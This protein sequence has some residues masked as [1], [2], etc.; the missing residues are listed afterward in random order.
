MELL[1]QFEI[2]L[3]PDQA[4]DVL[5][6]IPRIAPCM[7][8]A[9]LTQAVDANAYKGNV[10]VKIG[11][12]GLT[13]SGMVRFQEV[14]S[15]NKKAVVKATGNDTRGRGSA[16]AVILFSLSALPHGSS[17]SIKTD[18]N[19]VGAVAQYGRGVG[20]IQAIAAELTAAFAKNLKA[21][22]DQPTERTDSIVSAQPSSISGLSLLG[23]SMLRMVRPDGTDKTPE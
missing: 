10:S 22:L 21:E 20:I 13:F 18:L 17:V 14:D 19:L 23:K 3:L 9:V 1:N 16:N 5:L 4:W 12:I 8:G 11:P 6:D 15:V 2:P 7:P